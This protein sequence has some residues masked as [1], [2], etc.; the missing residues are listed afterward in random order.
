[1]GIQHHLPDPFDG[2][3]VLWAEVALWVSPVLVDVYE[4][5]FRCQ[6][7]GK[8]RDVGVSA[9]SDGG[10]FVCERLEL[11]EDLPGIRIAEP[12]PVDDPGQFVRDVGLFFED[13][14][15]QH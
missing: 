7:E 8:L 11:A 1:M 15:E 6:S 4:V 3:S 5:L 9:I 12:V 14:Y 13:V 10:A 2:D